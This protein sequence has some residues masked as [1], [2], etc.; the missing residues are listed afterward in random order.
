MAN[1]NKVCEPVGGVEQFLL[2]ELP[3]LKQRRSKL[4]GVLG[5]LMIALMLSIIASQPVRAE[6]ECAA[7]DY[8]C[9]ELN[10]DVIERALDERLAKFEAQKKAEQAEQKQRQLQADRLCLADD[11]PYHSRVD[12]C[13]R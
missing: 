1:L 8:D 9:I 6:W 13:E 2:P 12:E 11:D 10:H 5:S 4:V 3:L 7:G